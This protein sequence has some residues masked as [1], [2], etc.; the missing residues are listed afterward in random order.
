MPP[1]P[2]AGPVA[3]PPPCLTRVTARGENPR[4]SHLQ[5]ARDGDP[6]TL[7]FLFVLSSSGWVLLLE[8][9]RV[10]TLVPE[11]AEAHPLPFYLASWATV[12]AFRVPWIAGS[13]E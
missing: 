3:P 7:T 12:S 10:G 6:S 2:D 1:L 4:I 8:T 9:A 11:E 5:T 13:L